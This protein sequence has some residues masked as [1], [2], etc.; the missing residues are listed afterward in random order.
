MKIQ[1]NVPNMACDA[2]ATSIT[3]AVKAVDS[4][5][6]VVAEPQTKRVEIETAASEG[7]VRQAIEQAGYTVA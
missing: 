2:C 6:Q 5:A 1:F 7:A 3:K 4:S